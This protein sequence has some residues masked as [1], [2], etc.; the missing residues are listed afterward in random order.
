MRR[1]A[2]WIVRAPRL[3]LVAAL[4]AMILAAVLGRNVAEKLSAGGF[5]DPHSASAQADAS[6]VKSFP[7]GGEPDFVVLVTAKSGSVDDVA[8][9]GT[10]LALTTRLSHDRAVV[11]AASY[12]TLD[13]APPLKSRN[14]RQALIFAVL[15]GGLGTRVKTAQRLSP[16]FTQRTT[17]L[18][19][20][21]TGLA[22]VARQVGE[23]SK[24]DVQRNEILT[25]PIIAV[26]LLIVFGTI[27]A[28]LLPFAV[29]AVAIVGTLLLL[30]V[31]AS[32]T[33]VS[34]FALNLTTALGLGL[35]IDYALFIV[36]RYREELEKGVS[37]RIAVARTMQTACRTVLFSAGTVMISLLTLV[38]F[39]FSYVRSFAYAGVT[40]VGLSALAAIVVLP[41]VLV[42][43]GARV[44]RGR[45]FK[46]G[47]PRDGGFWRRQAERVMRHPWP[48]TLGV[49][50]ALLVLALPFTRIQL[51]QIDD[52][53]VP[54]DAASSRAAA[55]EIR[56]HFV[57][58]ENGALR[59]FLPAVNPT[60]D[61]GVIDAFARRLRALPGVARVDTA[62]GFYYSTGQTGPPIPS[63]LLT[64]RFFNK[65]TPNQT[66]VNVVPNVEPISKAGERLVHTVRNTTAPFHFSVAGPSA[67]LV[68]AKQTIADRLPIALGIIAFVT[69]LLLFL[70][71]GSLLVPL[72][73][74]LLNALSLTA[75]FGAMVFVFQDG[76][77][78]GLLNYTPTGSIDT[79]TPLLMFCIAFGLSMDYEVF[80]LSRI[81]EEY[82]YDRDNE[83]AV[84]V[85]LGKTGKI[86]TAAAVILAI[87]FVGLTTSAVV[88][89]KLFGLG[90][91]LAVLVDAF[92][93]RATLVPAF[94][95]L[96]GR[97]N[98]WAPRAVRRWHLRWGIWEREPIKI[99]DRAFERQ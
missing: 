17:S 15:R 59:L 81:K 52:R 21:V 85:G 98:W 82:D 18:R 79:F 91:A 95:R 23:R 74:M 70:M 38:L 90:L 37:T 33:E 84:A 87:A 62:T 61:A 46:A 9:T 93:I 43:L 99:L 41:A 54:P 65:R 57:S 7:A 24:Q 13:H 25:A 49:T 4:V 68:D 56:Q 89:V 31:I 83:R 32:T 44:E 72:K 34:V 28:A 12:W 64:S 73:A 48:Y 77:F 75:T 66:W 76:R 71:T 63:S 69:F 27:V 94:M 5:Q 67:R 1:L 92:L 30:L 55:D 8:T 80:L 3:V 36:S 2:G 51:G 22:E 96:A 11:A 45:L 60:T 88:Q 86:V 42:V 39:P 35:A 10:G 29:A 16:V 50:A 53:V 20:D 97:A 58:R 26:A 40:V 47:E 19:T 6:L 78:S 14:G